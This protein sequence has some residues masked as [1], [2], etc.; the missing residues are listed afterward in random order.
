MTDASSGQALWRRHPA[1]V[2]AYYNALKVLRPPPDLDLSAW[3][4]G[5]P[6]KPHTGRR[7]SAEASSEPGRWDTSRAEY[8]RGIMNAISDPNIPEVAVMS[9][10]QVGKTELLLNAIGYYI[11]QDPAPILLLQPT[12][13]MGE[14][15]SKDRLAPMV[16]DTPC[17]AGKIKDSRK[18]DSGNTLLHKTFPG[19][20]ITIAGSNSPASLASRPIR[21]VLADEVDRYPISAGSEGDP[22]S[23]AKK[24]TTTFWNRKFVAVSTPTIKGYS[25]IEM[26]W[27]ASDQRHFHVPCHHCGHKHPLRWKNV[28]WPSGQPEKAAYH[29][30]E[31]G[32]EWTDAERWRN[33]RHGEWVASKP[34]RGIA[35][36]HLNEIYSSWVRLSEMASNFLEA[37]RSPETLKTWV[38]TSLGEPWEED[39]SKADG[40][41]LSSRAEKWGTKDNE[42]AVPNSVLVVTVGVDVQDDRLEA[43]RVGWGVDEESWSLD[44]KIFYGDPS[45]KELWMDLNEYLYTPSVRE[46]GMVIPVSATCVDS[47]GHHT[48]MVYKFTS[49]GERRR[50][51]AI[52]GASQPS[53]P[54]WPKR[55]SKVGA[56]YNLW[57]IGTDSAKD[58]IYS[59]F[60]LQKPGPGYCHFPDDR[61]QEY[62]DQLTSEVIR[63]KYVKGFPVREYFL[64]GGKRNEALD[65]RVYAY[66]AMVSLNI[67][68]GV[69]LAEQQRAMSQ[70]AAKSR[71]AKDLEASMSRLRGQDAPEPEEIE[72]EPPPPRQRRRGRKRSSSWMN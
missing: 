66:A 36:F 4:D 35:G 15:F 21:V 26:Q 63:T 13:E 20:H 7:L 67:K 69:M 45:S 52:K 68:W 58:V 22:I 56:G 54:V 23:L 11:D 39:A 19:G 51:Y 27:E 5:D 1:V 32:V 28:Q 41:A 3:A 50:L 6:D 42:D 43:E 12:L 47:G 2:R 17:L 25:R 44:H 72:D 60:K 53:K 37:K 31:C 14:A 49:G 64:P 18:R 61:D 10:A 34:F 71:I 55:P 65:I 24:R 30:E 57:F 9:S 38:N 62:Y 48:Q 29:C 40:K 8:A 46:D 70:P 59:R 33:I 16:R